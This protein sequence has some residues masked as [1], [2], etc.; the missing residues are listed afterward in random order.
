[1][2]KK[3]SAI[4]AAGSACA[5]ESSSTINHVSKT[6]PEAVL[7]G[8]CA[9]AESFMAAAQSAATKRAYAGDLRHFLSHGGAL[10]ATPAMLAEYLARCAEKLSVATL[11]RRVTAIHK[12]HLEIS[13]PSPAL[14]AMVKRTLQGIRRTLGTKQRQAKP[15]VKDDVLAALVLIDQ[16]AP[17]KAA[18]DRALLLVG[19]ASA[20]RRSELVAVRMEHLTELAHGI[21]IFLPSSKTDQ[22]RAGRTVFIPHANG[23]RCPVRALQHWLEIAQIT[24]GCVFRAVTRHNKAAK[25]GLS[26]QS[27]A[28]IVK[29]A[30][31]RVGGD[32]EQVSGHSL[33]AGYCTQAAMVGLQPWQI[34]EQTGHRSDV[35]LAKYIRPVARR[36]IP[37]LL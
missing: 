13:A 18:R 29:A 32:P 9:T 34:R 31:E 26:A 5:R 35:T 1:M 10:P 6:P 30:V 24:E 33:R 21:E 16:Q 11:E 3:S 15:M 28:L 12:A 2:T 25:T 36:K 14:D 7:D 19:F 4:P 23:E 8:F 27:V 37:S 22:E 17:V 20:M